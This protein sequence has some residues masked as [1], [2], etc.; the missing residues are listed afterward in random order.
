[1]RQLLVKA[2]LGGYLA[3]MKKNVIISLILAV[4]V[5]GLAS[6]LIENCRTP[7]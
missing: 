6:F 5:I 2:S 1:M 3:S 4:A 7:F